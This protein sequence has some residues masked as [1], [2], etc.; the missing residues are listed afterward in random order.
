MFIQQRKVVNIFFYMVNYRFKGEGVAQSL[1]FVDLELMLK[2]GDSPLGECSV[3][4]NRGGIG[5]RAE[6]FLGATHYFTIG[7]H[8]IL[9]L[10]I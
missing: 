4:I 6:I 5:V 1:R 10:R 2:I 8:K 9:G 7:I 3:F